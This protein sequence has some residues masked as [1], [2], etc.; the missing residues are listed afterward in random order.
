MNSASD[1]LI[2]QYRRVNSSRISGGS[3]VFDPSVI[4]NKDIEGK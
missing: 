1:H 2:A 4:Y 3:E